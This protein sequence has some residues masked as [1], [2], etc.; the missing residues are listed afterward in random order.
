MTT[1]QLDTSSPITAGTLTI[2]ASDPAHIAQLLQQ[3]LQGHEDDVI[4]QPGTHHAHRQ[5]VLHQDGSHYYLTIHQD[6]CAEA[7]CH[8]C[9]DPICAGCN[10]TVIVS[11]S[12]QGNRTI[13][14]GPC[15]GLPH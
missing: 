12:L 1:A 2:A 9:G 7:R 15:Q 3:G 14:C 4:I 8:L 5:P 11:I 6:Q 10:D 13:T